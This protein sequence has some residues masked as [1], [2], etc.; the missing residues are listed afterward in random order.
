MV[1]FQAYESYLPKMKTRKH[2]SPACSAGRGLG[3]RYMTSFYLVRLSS[4][5]VWL[6]SK[7]LEKKGLQSV[8]SAE[9]IGVA[10][11]EGISDPVLYSLLWCCHQNR[12][13]L[14]VFLHCGLEYLIMLS[15]IS[16]LAFYF[17]VCLFVVGF[18]FFSLSWNCLSSYHDLDCSSPRS[19][20]KLKLWD[21]S[22]LFS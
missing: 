16:G 22:V 5:S 7:W 20:T 4:M 12:N 8:L 10:S 9:R 13:F 1:N 18:V 2:S 21:F 3:G 15:I 11:V 6:G 19:D 14:R 17:F